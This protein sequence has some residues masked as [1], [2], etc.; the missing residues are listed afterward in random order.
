VANILDEMRGNSVIHGHIKSAII[1]VAPSGKF[2]LSSFQLAAV[3]PKTLEEN[4]E[5]LLYF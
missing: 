4:V 1:F 3:D 2:R 5:T